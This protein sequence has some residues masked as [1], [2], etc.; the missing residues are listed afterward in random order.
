MTCGIYKITNKTNGKAYIGAS[1]QIEERWHAHKYQRSTAMNPIIREYGKTNFTFEILEECLIEELRE[2]ERYYIKTHNTKIPNGYNLT[3]GGEL[4]INSTGYYKVHKTKSDSVSIGYLFLYMISY[5]TNKTLSSRS[6][7]ELEKKVKE[8]NLPWE[9]LDK[10]KAD[11]TLQQNL[12]DL[13]TPKAK[14]PRNKTGYYNVYKEKINT[15]IQDYTWIYSYIEH[16]KKVQIRR[17]D[18]NEL[19]EEI[20]NS[21]LKWEIID[22]EKAKISDKEN[23]IAIKNHPTRKLTGYYRVQI[24]KLKNLVLGYRFEYKYDDFQISSCSLRV[25]EQKIKCKGL[26]WTILDEKIAA[27]TLEKNEIDL[28]NINYSPFKN[29]TGLYNVTKCTKKE[30]KKGFIYEYNFKDNEKNKRINLTSV[31]ISRLEQKVKSKTLPWLII[32]EEKFKRTLE[33]DELAKQRWEKKRVKKKN[34]RKD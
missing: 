21:G 12:K 6:I 30:T 23:R 18:L 24:H 34:K 11:K 14:Y 16:G 8:N 32:N 26:K 28:K 1:S 5:E 2:K 31:D 25:L 3:D 19:R 27:Q 4:S 13:N 20:L 7:L 17:W 15:G 29:N 22:E 9:I 33:E 10:A